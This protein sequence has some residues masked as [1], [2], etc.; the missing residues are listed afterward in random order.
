[1]LGTL[2]EAI[3]AERARSGAGGGGR[4]ESEP[5]WEEPRARRRGFRL[6]G[7]LLRIGGLM[8]LLIAAAVIFLLMVFGGLVI[9]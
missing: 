3:A 9:G 2:L 1:M 8:F 7:C 6:G 5:P 4:Y